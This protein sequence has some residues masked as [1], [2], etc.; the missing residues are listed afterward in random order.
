MTKTST[1]QSLPDTEKEE[2][3]HS[4][5]EIGI[6]YATPP[7]LLI[8]PPADH[9]TAKTWLVIFVSKH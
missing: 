3:E 4:H 8:E 2:T 6:D 1:E 7:D 9:V 5:N